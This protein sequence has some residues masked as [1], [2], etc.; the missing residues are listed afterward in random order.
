MEI[1]WESQMKHYEL[2]SY[3]LHIHIQQPTGYVN[4]E[5]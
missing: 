4:G 5:K 2:K 1:E 3:S